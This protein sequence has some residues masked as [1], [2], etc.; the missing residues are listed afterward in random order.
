MNPKNNLAHCFSCQQN[1]N[2]I[3]L[4]LLQGHDFVPAVTILRRWLE[5]YRDDLG[6]PTPSANSDSL[7]T[8]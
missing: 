3:D 2:N 8:S 5:D 4:M 7:Q 1:T 6:D